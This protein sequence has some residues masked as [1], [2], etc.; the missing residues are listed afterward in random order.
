ML[1]ESPSDLD[2]AWEDVGRSWLGPLL[3][4]LVRT[5]HD[6]ALALDLATEALAAARTEWREPIVGD[7]ALVALLE[8]CARTLAAAAERGT[9]P[10]V[11]RRRHHHDAPRR[12]TAAAQ[13]ELA[14]LAEQHLDLSTAAR[15]AAEALART[16]PPP[17]ALRQ[18]RLSGLVDVEPLSSPEPVR[19]GG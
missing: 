10:A 3:A 5:V 13:R 11:E 6:G 7:S 14:R 17:A 15:A 9:V 2:R 19:D 16:A 12:L 8:L 18:L 1:D 4:L